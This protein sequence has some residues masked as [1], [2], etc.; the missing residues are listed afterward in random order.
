MV[1]T[2]ILEFCQ[3]F[4]DEEACLNWIFEKKFGGHTPC[5]L[6]DSFGRWTK[7]KGTKKFQHA[8]H[9]QISLLAGTAFYRSN[10][11]L[12]ACFYAMLLF[13]N[14]SSGVRTSFLRKQLGLGTKSA[15]R[16]SNCIRLHMSA[17]DRPTQLGGPGKLVEVD[18]VLLRHLRKPGVPNLDSALV[19]G[20]AC[21]EQVLCGIVPDRKRETLHRNIK[22]FVA[23][24]SIVVTDD[25]VA[26]RKLADLGFRHITVNHSQG[27]FNT[28]GYSTG[29]IDSYWAVVRRAM[30][31]Y[32]QVSQYNLWLFIAEIECRYNMRHST[33]SIFDTLVSHWPSV[34]G[35]DLEAL[36]LKYDWS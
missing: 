18:E 8:C 24:D 2:G 32:H 14:S 30:R 17:W 9:K 10:I 20:I 36:R 34:I 21:E 7:V 26:Y 5:P 28:E 19:M 1:G 15:H 6:C 35:D 31:G 22:K 4:P 29:K 3:R 25:W 23:P 11:P 27:Y 16:L 33:E 12:S 13:A